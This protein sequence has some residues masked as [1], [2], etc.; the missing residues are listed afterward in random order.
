MLF[1]TSANADPFDAIKAVDVQATKLEAD[2]CPKATNRTECKLDFLDLK[3]E[4]TNIFAQLT[5]ALSEPDNARQI[6][7]DAKKR[8]DALRPRMLALTVKYGK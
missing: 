1:C 6:L 2:L 3:T 7:A 8:F 5:L 4:I